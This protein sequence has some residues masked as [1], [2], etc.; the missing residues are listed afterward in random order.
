MKLILTAPIITL[1][2]CL[3]DA[4]KFKGQ[5]AVPKD[6]DCTC[7]GYEKKA[8]EC[9]WPQRNC[10]PTSNAFIN[11]VYWCGKLNGFRQ[12]KR[13]GDTEATYNRTLTC[14]ANLDVKTRTSITCG[15]IQP[16]NEIASPRSLPVMNYPTNATLPNFANWTSWFPAVK[17][18]GSKKK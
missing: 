4:G 10:D 7:V 14:Y 18:Q 1:F 15:L 11:Y 9:Q 13:N 6:H 3:A 8:T 12:K 17:D 16:Q 2:I 5:T